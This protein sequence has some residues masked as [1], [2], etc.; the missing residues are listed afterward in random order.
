MDSNKVF[1][2][3]MN[4]HGLSGFVMMLPYIEQTAVYDQIAARNFSFRPWDAEPATT[5]TISAFLCPSDGSA[6]NNAF[7]GDDVRGNSSY[8]LSRGDALPS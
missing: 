1:P 4:N 8:V 2:P 3:G 5:T 7:G 6:G